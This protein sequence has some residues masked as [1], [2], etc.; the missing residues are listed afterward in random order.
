[1]VKFKTADLKKKALAAI[2][3]EKL[4]KIGDIE[5]FLPVGRRTFYD[6]KLHED[7]DILEALETVA[8]GK[9]VRMRNKWEDSDS[10]ALQIAAFK[11]MADEDELER[12]SQTTQ[13]HKGDIGLQITTR[14]ILPTPLPAEEDDEPK[15]VPGNTRLKLAG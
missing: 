3:K 8:K 10:P 13:N 5:A 12:L 14:V 6:H 2:K 9:K 7:P 11:L 15:Q 1:M 4:T